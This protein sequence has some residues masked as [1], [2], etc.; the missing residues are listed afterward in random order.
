M[1]YSGGRVSITSDGVNSPDFKGTF[2]L[3]PGITQPMLWDQYSPLYTR[4]V[5]HGVKVSMKVLNGSDTGTNKLHGMAGFIIHDN[6]VTG[7]VDTDQWPEVVE[8]SKLGGPWVLA[9][10]TFNANQTHGYRMSKYINLKKHFGPGMYQGYY[11]LAG[12]TSSAP[13]YLNCTPFI[14]PLYALDQ[15]SINLNFEVTYYLTMMAAQHSEVS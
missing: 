12:Q 6:T 9:Y 11:A 14:A 8:N 2:T 7:P 13:L 10:R 5:V 1:T 15:P 4:H 3:A